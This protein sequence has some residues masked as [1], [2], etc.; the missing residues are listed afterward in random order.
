MYWNGDLPL[1][2][3]LINQKPPK[4]FLAY[5]SDGPSGEEWSYSSDFDDTRY[6]YASIVNMKETP[7]LFI[8]SLD[9]EYPQPSK[10]IM[11]EVEDLSS[12]MRVLAPLSAR[13][14]TVFPLW[15]FE[16]EGKH[17]IGSVI[18][19]EHYYEADALPV[20]FYLKTKD[21][22]QG[23]FIR[24]SALK[25]SGEKLEYAN[26]TS[27]VKYFYAKLIDVEGMSFLT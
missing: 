8:K 14:G 17:Y 13:E 21:P 4:P 6:R 22:P 1:L 9:G 24:Y 3:Y 5:R 20:F 12:I 25:P 11:M 16:K 15:H 19:F 2:A 7:D 26:S 10:P 23:P 27:D 18:P